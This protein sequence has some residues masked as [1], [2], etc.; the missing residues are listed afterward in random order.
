MLILKPTD[1][2]NHPTDDYEVYRTK[3]DIPAWAVL[4]IGAL[5]WSL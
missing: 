1:L 4:A 5:N 3:A 2:P